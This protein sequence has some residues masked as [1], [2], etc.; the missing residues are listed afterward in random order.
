MRR[1]APLLALALLAGCTLTAPSHGYREYTLYRDDPDGSSAA[2][3]VDRFEAPVYYEY[4]PMEE[5]DGLEDF[6]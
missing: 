5:D 3:I 1:L 6:R 4:P 2:V